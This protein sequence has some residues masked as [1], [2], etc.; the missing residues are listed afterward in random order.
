MAKRAQGLQEFEIDVGHGH[1]TWDLKQGSYQLEGEEVVL[2]WVET[3]L[4]SF[5]DTIEEVSGDD[6]ASVVMETAGYRMGK[7]VVDFFKAE[8]GGRVL[9]Y[10]PSI[11]AS[12]GWGTVDIVEACEENKSFTIRFTN[13]W[14]YKINKAQGK[15]KIGS[16]IPGHWAGLL[17]SLYETEMGYYKEKSQVEG[18]EY[19]E[20]LFYPTNESPVE[21]IHTFS[22]RRE[23]EEIEKLEALVSD[24]T[25]EL[26]NLVR[27][28]SSPII[29]VLENVVVVPMLGKY[30]RERAEDML[31]QIMYRIPEYGAR[32]LILDLTGIDENIDEFAITLINRLIQATTLLGIKPILV[33]ISP[34]LSMQLAHSDFDLERVD[35]FANLKHGVHFALAQEGKQIMG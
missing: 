35:C 8:K 10:L 25:A 23:Q 6:A 24:R 26:E 29:P 19:D 28:I 12:A 3:A 7:I 5:I 18:D 34:K 32:Y 11:Y 22:R 1:Y 13:T 14:E 2:F 21:N 33:G 20:F 17:T 30:D 4:K 15:K 9:D 27:D 16:F 31:D